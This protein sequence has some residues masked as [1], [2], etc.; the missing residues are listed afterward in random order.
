MDDNRR[1]KLDLG[2]YCP[3]SLWLDSFF[4]VTESSLFL[5]SLFCTVLNV[6]RKRAE[7]ESDFDK[8]SRTNQGN[9]NLDFDKFSMTN[10]GTT[11]WYFCCYTNRDSDQN[12]DRFKM[13]HHLPW[14]KYIGEKL[15]IF[16]FGQNRLKINLKRLAS[17]GRLIK[18]WP[19][20]I[21]DQRLN[22]IN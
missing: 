12:V 2:P 5:F 1:A 22:Q 18:C 19:R 3:S 9:T 13:P 7:K 4:I 21:E 8:F 20:G 15:H 14:G 10:Q 6:F 11:N 16:A 17:I